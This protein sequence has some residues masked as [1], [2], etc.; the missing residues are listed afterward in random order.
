MSTLKAPQYRLAFGDLIENRLLHLHRLPT[1]GR[2]EAAV[3][4]LSAEIDAVLGREAEVTGGDL[5]E[6]FEQHVEV[7]TSLNHTLLAAK[8][9][10]LYPAAKRA[11][12]TA[13]HDTLLAERTSARRSPDER[14][15]DALLA[16]SQRPRLQAALELFPAAPGERSLAALV[17]L[18]IERGE[19]LGRLSSARSAPA[20]AQ[21]RTL[22]AIVR[23][24]T[25]LVA[26]IRA[27]VRLELKEDP[28][29]PANLEAQVLGYFDALRPSRRRRAAGATASAAP[30]AAAPAA[31][32]PVSPT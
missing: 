11:A 29:V 4:R 6:A 32:A 8:R 5:S 24:A 25:A 10:P 23:D 16:R 22:P 15:A 27:A 18:W 21:R 2:D 13:L 28:T 30:A 20:D 31:P 1:G 9:N 17:H 3:R 26:R 19:A 7:T 12:A 14:A